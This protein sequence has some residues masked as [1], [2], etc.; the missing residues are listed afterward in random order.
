VT[1][2]AFH[3]VSG[4]QTALREEDRILRTGEERGGHR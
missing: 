2:M 1:L 3:S 4:A